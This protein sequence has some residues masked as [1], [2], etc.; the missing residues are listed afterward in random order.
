MKKLRLVFISIFV[1]VVV[2]LCA[3]CG[4]GNDSTSKPKPVKPAKEPV[5]YVSTVKLNFD[6]NT[7]KQEVTVRLYVDGDT[8]H[9]NPVLSSSV[10]TN[11]ASDFAD[12][13]GYI[14]ARYLAIN[15]PECTSKI[16][17][18]G[19][20]AARFTRSKL[21]GAQSIVLESDDNKWNIDS[22]GS[23]R[24][25]VWIWY[26]PQGET[27]YRN[28]NLEILQEGL[29]FGSNVS[30][31]RYGPTAMAAMMQAT[32][33]KRY[34]FSKDKDPDYPDGDATPVTL[35][36]LRCNIEDYV[37]KNV[38]VEGVITSL[39]NN[40]AYIE[41]FDADTGVYFGMSVYYGFQPGALIRF[42]EVGNRLSVVGVVAYWEGGGTYQI[43]N[44]SYNEYDET[45]SSNTTLVSSGNEL[46]FAEVS[47][48]NIVDGELTVYLDKETKDENGEI[49]T[50]TV[51]K[52]LVYGEA[53]MS[54]SVTVKNLTVQR[55]YTTSNG[56]S[57]DG[58]MSLTCTADDGTTIVVRTE[59]L[60]DEDGKLITEEAYKGKTITVKGIVDYYKAEGQEKGNYQVKVYRADFIEILDEDN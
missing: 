20:A 50:E 37:G 16:E 25:T 46:G 14:K 40:S 48:K 58:A 30:G 57:S 29:A 52:K 7:K 42:L 17:P 35:K 47:A 11:P 54:T 12:T 8:T 21:E 10:A 32:E 28:L 15:T 2:A 4:G 5:D 23:S 51:E 44:V 33:L 53:I 22:S 1:L 18:W 49:T 60:K 41:D 43:S 9:F 26:K 6:S 24:Y 31:N 36:E 19:Y 55:I 34:V 13:D 38:K 56:G 3:A 39:F 27:E 59:V 45:L